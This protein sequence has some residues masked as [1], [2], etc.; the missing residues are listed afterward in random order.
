MLSLV[1]GDT[2]NACLMAAA[3]YV[4][5]MGFHVATFVFDGFMIVKDPEGRISATDMSH[6]VVE[7]TG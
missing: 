6:R 3:A 2:K 1:M 7:A 4:E 5:T